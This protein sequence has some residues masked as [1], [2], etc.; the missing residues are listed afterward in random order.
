MPYI[1]GTIKKM[2]LS[3]ETCMNHRSL[4]FLTFRMMPRAE[5][6]KKFRELAKK[7]YPDTIGDSSKFI[8]LMEN[9][10]KLID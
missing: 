6:K 8:E 7:Y 2:V 9:Y 10:K 5:I 1:T 3:A 4:P